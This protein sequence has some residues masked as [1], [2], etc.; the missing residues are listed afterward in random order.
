[1]VVVAFY[2]TRNSALDLLCFVD[3]LVPRNAPCGMAAWDMWISVGFLQ[4]M[5]LA[6]FWQGPWIAR[7]GSYG[8]GYWAVNGAEKEGNV[9]VY[10]ACLWDE[11]GVNK[12][13]S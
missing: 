8:S 9:L 10:L 12:M 7:L 13:A 4:E 6:R 2:A 5:F 1:M 3:Q 11:N